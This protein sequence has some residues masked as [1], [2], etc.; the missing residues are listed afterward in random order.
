MCETKVI[1]ETRGGNASVTI[2]SVTLHH[3]SVVHLDV[4]GVESILFLL[5]INTNRSSFIAWKLNS[6]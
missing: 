6:V 2:L 3:L 1:A 4:R 5:H